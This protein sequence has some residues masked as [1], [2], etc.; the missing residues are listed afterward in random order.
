MEFF[1][2]LRATVRQLVCSTQQTCCESMHYAACNVEHARIDSHCTSLAK[3]LSC[4][5]A[6]AAAAA[7]TKQFICNLCQ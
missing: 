2:E 6:A 4:G 5:S 7:V 1:A 3:P